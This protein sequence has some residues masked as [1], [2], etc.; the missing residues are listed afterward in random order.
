[1]LRAR[2]EQAERDGGVEEAR[3]H[4]RSFFKARASAAGT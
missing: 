4:G 1:V 2:A 3:E